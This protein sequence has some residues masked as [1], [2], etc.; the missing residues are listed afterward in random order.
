LDLSG[1]KYDG[2]KFIKKNVIHALYQVSIGLI[3]SRRIRWAGHVAF[4][5]KMHT[6]KGGDHL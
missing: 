6:L 2:E 5:G 3:K 4:M 1:R